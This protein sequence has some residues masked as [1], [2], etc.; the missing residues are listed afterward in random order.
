M[1]Q[2]LSTTRMTTTSRET[3]NTLSS[4]GVALHRQLYMV[5]RDEI[6]RGLYSTGLL[7]SYDLLCERFGV[8]RITVRRA[9]NDLAAHGVVELQQGKGTVVRQSLKLPLSAPSLTLMD[10]LRQ[11]TPLVN[12]VRVL[13]INTQL[14]PS[15][16]ARQLQL[17]AGAK[18]VRILRL[19]INRRKEPGGLM[20]VW[21]PA[22]HGAG[23]TLAA[24]RRRSA[25]E[26]LLDQGVRFGRV[27]QVFSATVCSP[28]QALLLEIP[29]GS[30][31]LKLERVI[32]D[33]DDRPVLHFVGRMPANR[34]GVLMETT[35]DSVNTLTAGMV[36]VDAPGD[37]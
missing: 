14:P 10:K 5:L 7:P 30:P 28:E 8:S 29:V 12:D 4:Q 20:D 15:D 16:I 13:E 3:L 9:V 25:Y 33:A 23:M 18:A 2:S 32:Y 24:M 36:F 11:A 31:L 17:G 1:E 26:V 27:V 21:V 6:E 35:G 22:D 19:R 34:G 37:G